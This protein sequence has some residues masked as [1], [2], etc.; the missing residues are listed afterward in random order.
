[1]SLDL[2]IIKEGKSLRCGYTTGSCAAGAAKAA[3]IMIETGET[4]KY[5]E[6]DTPANIKLKLEVNN[7]SIDGK[8]ATCS[9]I[10]D[11]GDD[12]DNTDGI[13]IYATLSKRDDGQ[14]IIEG[15]Q[16]IGRIRRK[17]LFGKVGEAAINPVPRQMIEKEVREVSN[18]GY[19]ILIF[20]PQGEE[21][22]KKTFNEN[23]GIEGG[24]SIIGTKGIV[25]PMSEEALIKTIYMEI[26]MLEETYGKSNI[27]LVPGNYGE[28]LAEELGIK[29]PK[30][31]VSNF[32]GNSLLYIY[33][34][35]FKSITLIGHIGKFSKLSIGVFNT[36]SKICD[37][38]MEAFI[39]YL[40]LM[41]APMELLNRVNNAVTAEEG[42]NI[43]ID[44]GYGEVIRRMEKGAEDRIRKYLKDENYKVKVI[45]YSMERGV[46]LC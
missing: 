19:D 23:I 12:P 42:L 36:H 31:K 27:V 44:A 35:G 8:K 21:I 1:M 4:V 16:G 32:L 6:I 11:A 37:G 13:E 14:V 25:Y 9:I 24:I 43:C 7:P 20:A 46:T 22:G 33:N 40:A 18:S 3:A 38:R 10:K 26:D 34:K 17:G 28:K 5:V 29:E 15:G 2:Y 41:G 45:I 39:Y 30:V